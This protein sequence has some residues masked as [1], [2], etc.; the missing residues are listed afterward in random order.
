MRFFDLSRLRLKALLLIF[1][2]LGDESVRVARAIEFERSAYVPFRASLS[3]NGNN[4][5]FTFT[6]SFPSHSHI[7][8]VP[9]LHISSINTRRE[10]NVFLSRVHLYINLPFSLTYYN[11]SFSSHLFNSTLDEKN[12]YFISTF[13]LNSHITTHREEDHVKRTRRYLTKFRGGRNVH[14][15]TKETF[16]DVPHNA[17]LLALETETRV[18]TEAKCFGICTGIAIA[19]AIAAGVAAGVTIGILVNAQ[20][21]L[22][23]LEDVVKDILSSKSSSCVVIR[24]IAFA[25]KTFQVATRA[26][27]NSIKIITPPRSSSED[28]VAREFIEKLELEGETDTRGNAD[29][30][31]NYLDT[32]LGSLEAHSEQVIKLMDR[33]TTVSCSQYVDTGLQ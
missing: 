3:I 8:T 5:V 11:C 10:K 12:T 20:A 31:Q 15:Q 26:F 9:F 18:G 6:S 2:V 21:T 19:V 24:K 33:V 27:S 28:N 32:M 22:L 4:H 23:K 17:V 13:S 14:E 30:L 1:L 29:K 7:T 16:G 25:T